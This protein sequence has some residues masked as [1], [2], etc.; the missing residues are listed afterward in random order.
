MEG[1]YAGIVLCGGR[2][3]RMGLPK[4]MLPFGPE[5]LLQRIVRQLGQAVE[6][7]LVV[8]SRAQPLPPLPEA[9]RIVYDREEGRGPLEGL[10][11][12]LSALTPPSEAAFV[13]GCDVATL[14][15]A[16]VARMTQLLGEHAIAVPVVDGFWQPLTAVYRREVAQAASSLLAGGNRGLQTLFDALPTRRVSAAELLDVDPELA[17]LENIN[18]PADYLAALAREKLAAV[19][20]I[21]R[22][23]SVR[24]DRGA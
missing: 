1:R 19:P 3:S 11:T 9:V 21:L 8:T 5:C 22:R 17:S 24:P 12:G 20:E 13:V 18:S 14:L 23:F 4:H 6:P 10:C 16:L 7:I 2:S 15:P